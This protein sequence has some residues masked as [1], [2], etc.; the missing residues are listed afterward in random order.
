MLLFQTD[1][2]RDAD[3]EGK[4]RSSRGIFPR[5]SWTATPGPAPCRPSRPRPR[6]SATTLGAAGRSRHAAALKDGL[7]ASFFSRLSSS[8]FYLFI[9]S[10]LSSCSAMPGGRAGPSGGRSR[11]ARW[12][13]APFGRNMA[14][15]EPF[16]AVLSALRRCY[17]AVV[18][19]ETFVRRLGNSE[20]G[21]AEVL[22][23]DDGP[24]YRTFVRE[25]FVCV[26]RGARAFPRPFTF[27]QVG[28]GPGAR[29]CRPC[30]AARALPGLPK[31]S[32]SRAPCVC[33]G[34]G[35]APG[36]WRLLPA[37]P[38]RLPEPWAAPPGPRASAERWE[39]A[40]ASPRGCE[41]GAQVP[42]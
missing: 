40:P 13:R 37:G 22:R 42:A 18:P 3:P 7:A 8:C 25:C 23:A 24:S 6:P 32:A 38:D 2:R 16:A 39:S 41:S 28:R 30:R 17:A 19:L 29:G 20:A 5:G 26:P 36:P 1:P 34:G 27:Q 9:N 31:D 33:G 4:Y 15:W 12:P 14:G 21:Y 11:W 35:A 10:P